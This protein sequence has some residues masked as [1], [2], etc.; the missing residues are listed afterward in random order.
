MAFS[1]RNIQ[2]VQGLFALTKSD[3]RKLIVS[4]QT[5]LHKH[6]V[7]ELIELIERAENVPIEK[8]ENVP[9]ETL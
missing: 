3:A 1:A 6:K 2:A 5:F 8:A 4:L 7:A 9:E